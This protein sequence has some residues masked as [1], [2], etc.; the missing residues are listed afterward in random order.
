MC[1][2]FS[3]LLNKM[4]KMLKMT[5]LLF[6]M[7]WINMTVSCIKHPPH[8]P[9]INQQVVQMEKVE[10]LIDEVRRKQEVFEEEQRKFEEEQRLYE[11]EQKMLLQEPEYFQ[12]HSNS[13]SSSTDPVEYDE[14]DVTQ[15]DDYPDFPPLI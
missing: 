11:E 2:Y 10:K 14:D 5:L 8:K 4:S 7:V 13:N 12:L 1:S 3:S 15:D 9:R 6:L